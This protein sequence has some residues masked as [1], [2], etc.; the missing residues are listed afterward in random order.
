MRQ[1]KRLFEYLLLIAFLVTA[2]DSSMIA[3]AA[4]VQ[5]ANRMN[6]VFVMDESGSM[7]NSDADKF[8]YDAMDL[9]MALATDTGNY[10]GAVVF[11]ADIL[12]QQEIMQI[13]GTNSKAALSR[14]V[15]N[16]ESKGLTDIGKAIEVAAEMLLTQ[17]NPNLSSAIILLSDGNTE[18]ASNSAYEASFASKENAINIARQNGYKVYSICLNANGSANS[19]ELEEISTAT[20]GTCV[21]VK[22]AEDLKEVFAQFYNIIYSTETIVLADLVIPESGEAEV[23]FKIP[24]IGVDEANII[25]STLNKDTS[26]TLTQPSGIAYT[27]E[28]LK[29]IKIT[30]KTFSVL[31]IQNPMGG[32]WKLVVK[33]VPGDNVKIEMVYNANL[34]MNTV[35][36]SGNMEALADEDVSI[37]AQLVD[38]GVPVDGAIYQNYPLHV[39]LRDVTPGSEEDLEC[40]DYVMDIED[41]TGIYVFQI[42]LYTKYDIYTYCE[43]D[44]MMISSEIYSITAPNSR[45]RSKENPI[46][47]NK[48]II[49]FVT[50]S[51]E[52]DLSE[53]IVDYEDSVLAYS[54]V[55]SDFDSST[56]SV[57]GNNLIIDLKKAGKGGE[58]YVTALDSQ[59]AMA[60]V[61]VIL[62]VTSLLPIVLL[63]LAVIIVLIA[64]P[65]MLRW[66]TKSR[67]LIRG[68]IMITPYTEEGMSDSKVYDGKRGKMYIRYCTNIGKNAGID[69]KSTYF[70]AGERNRHIYLISKSGYYTD[71]NSNMKSKKIR[72]DGEREVDISSDMYFARGIKVVYLPDDMG[73]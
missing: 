55:K 36:N 65:V 60:E 53:Y 2:V 41:N 54:I 22:S 33:G 10:M 45:P 16:V 18:L 6:V 67:K 30:A 34:A 51:D 52:V 70:I 7:E 8:R 50:V 69:M 42:P 46:P 29:D 1:K 15:R 49:P 71:S 48:W 17:A 19:G 61:Q 72:L 63:V 56:V 4:D 31:K 59:G 39:V 9:F 37:T 5:N 40:I 58:F 32:E 20:G 47:I 11:N 68:K 21:E 66:W 26:Y 23:F 62:K 64:V 24:L 27:A 25:I 13:D 28:E 43:I 73:Y 44:N 3:K 38:Y 57:D 35:V 12:L 14:K